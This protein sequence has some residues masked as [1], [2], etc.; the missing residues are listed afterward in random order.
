MWDETVWLRCSGKDLPAMHER[1]EAEDP[2]RRISRRGFI[3]LAGGIGGAILVGA[4]AAPAIADPTPKL[5]GEYFRKANQVTPAGTVFDN[6]VVRINGDAA[7]IHVPQSVKPY[8]GVPVQVVWFYHGSGSD[9]NALDGGF[10]TSAAAVVDRGA[11]AICQTAGGTIYS[12][13]TAVS[14]QLA[15]YSYMTS[16]FAISSS[17]LRST[18]GGGALACETYGSRLIPGIAGMYNVNSVYDIRA[19]YDAGGTGAATIVAAFGDD[20]AAIDAANP[21]RLPADAWV[22]SRLRIVVAA[23]SE[24]DTIVPPDDHGLALLALAQPVAA[25]ASLRTHSNGHST[26][27][28]A[29]SDFV[30]AIDR[31]TGPATPPTGDT[32]APSVSIISPVTGSTVSGY[33]TIAVTATD[34]TGVVDVGVYVAGQR[35]LTLTQ[36]NSTTWGARVWTRTAATPNGTYA[37][38]ARATD[39]AGNVGVSAPITVTVAN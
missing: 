15:G 9:H 32:K 12:H 17:V 7:R 11:I 13:P 35:M 23:P 2:A 5:P 8:S 39:A 24:T 34:D 25:E 18:S 6:I 16:L 37:V 21:A 33:A 10:K 22:D 38:T 20:P 1:S 31:W 3:G 14:L 26:P 4:T 30:A 27:G 19:T 28:F 36:Q 29:V